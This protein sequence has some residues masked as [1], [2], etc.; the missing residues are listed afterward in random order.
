VA[1]RLGFRGMNVEVVLRGLGSRV[2][3]LGFGVQSLG[4]R[5]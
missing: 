1:Q 3:G 2:Y 4:S 5:V